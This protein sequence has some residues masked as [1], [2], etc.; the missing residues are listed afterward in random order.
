M[1]ILCPFYVVYLQFHGDQWFL[2][3]VMRVL[4]RRMVPFSLA[5]LSRTRLFQTCVDPDTLLQ[6]M[7]K[8]KGV[9]PFSKWEKELPKIIFDPRFKVCA[10][11]SCDTVLFFNS[12]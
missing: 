2:Q 10:M 7:L 3:L 4:L 1:S 11:S 12:I 5:S 9:A 8:E 6:E